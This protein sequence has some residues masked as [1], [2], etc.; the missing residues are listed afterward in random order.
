[1]PSEDRYVSHDRPVEC[2][3]LVVDGSGAPPEPWAPA[4]DTTEHIG[5]ASEIAARVGSDE[6][7]ELELRAMRK[8]GAT[9]IVGGSGRADNLLADSDALDDGPSETGPLARS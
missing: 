1:M 6:L 3:Q 7:V 2:A 4:A 5:G 8:E 9:L